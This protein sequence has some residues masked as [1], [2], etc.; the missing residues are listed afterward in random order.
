M[1][2]CVLYIYIYVYIY[3]L[4]GLLPKGRLTKSEYSELR[5]MEKDKPEVSIDTYMHAHRSVCVVVLHTHVHG[6]D[7][8]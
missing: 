5:H 8:D 7:S 1:C 4:S 6:S 3:I 2:V